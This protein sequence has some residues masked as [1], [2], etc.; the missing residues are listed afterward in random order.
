MD[1]SYHVIGLMSGTSL[2]GLDIAHCRITY[3]SQNWI[4]EI[5]NTNTS[6]YD[7]ILLESLRTVETASALDLVALDHSF[8]RFV[9]QQVRAFVEQH[10]LQPD[11]IASHGHTI[12]HQPDK[13]ISLQIG[14]GAY[15]AAHARL[16]VIS[17]FRTLDIALGGQ[18]A[19][20]VPIGDELLF[21]AY[22]NCINL[23]GIANVSY[24]QNGQRIAFDTGACNMLLNSLANSIGKPYDENGDLARSGTMQHDLLQQLNAPA[25]FSS[26]APKSL[27]KEWVSTHSLQSIAASDS[28]VVDKLH[29][30]CHHIAQQIAQALP[31]LHKGLHRVLLTGG[32]AFN[33]YLVE[34]I[35]QQLGSAYRVE[36]PE[37]EVVSYKEALLFAFLGVLRWRGE[38]NCLSSVTGASRNNIGGSIYLY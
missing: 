11:F 7:D 14:H 8:G 19:P 13:H 4:Y 9:G 26:P 28:A 10:D 25:Y 30:A 37:P 35:Q 12:F 31:P 29:T 36:V 23:G 27:G 20:L 38:H 22:D 32:G 1:T 18:G 24:N 3:K 15:I 33:L 2:D 16:P 6:T 21:S 34:Q 17:D 5:L